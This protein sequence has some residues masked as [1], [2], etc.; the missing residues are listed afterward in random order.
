MI[1]EVVLRK[2]SYPGVWNVRLACGHTIKVKSIKRPR[3]KSAECPTCQNV[4]EQ[5]WN[6]IQTDAL[7]KSK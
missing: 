6:D 1:R 7:F 4:A 5:E 3:I 2:R